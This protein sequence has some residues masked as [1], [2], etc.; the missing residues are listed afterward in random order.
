MQ[1]NANIKEIVYKLNEKNLKF[2]SLFSLFIMST[3]DINPKQ[4]TKD[5]TVFIANVPQE[6][7]FGELRNIFEEVGEVEKVYIDYKRKGIAFVTYKQEGCTE[8]AISRLNGIEYRGKALAVKIY[9]PRDKGYQ[10]N[11]PPVK[12][13]RQQPQQQRRTYPPRKEEMDFESE[14]DYDR[15]PS[16]ENPMGPVPIM[17]FDLT[18]QLQANM[19]QQQQQLA[20]QAQQ[21][22]QYGMMM[23]PMVN[24]GLHPLTIQPIQPN[25]L[26]LTQ[27]INPLL[28][29]QIAQPMKQSYDRSYRRND[30]YRSYDG[31]RRDSRRD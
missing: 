13:Y 1:E 15:Q 9:R 21:M 26:M 4:S 11:E 27:G 5:F 29:N 28:T 16:P 3:Y 14:Y 30:S 18:N 22:G 23:P 2:P 8:K 6:C 20:L 24:M 19:L 31:R 12:G 17:G 7:D 10:R 25:P